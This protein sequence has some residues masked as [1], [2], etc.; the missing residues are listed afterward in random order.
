MGARKGRKPSVS[1]FSKESKSYWLEGS[2]SFVIA[3][4]LGLA[5]VI[6]GYALYEQFAKGLPLKKVI[7]EKPL[8]YGAASDVL[9]V[10]NAHENRG[11]LRSDVGKI[12]QELTELGWVKSAV[13]K[14][15]WYDSLEVNIQ[16]RIPVLRWG[17]SEY[18]DKEGVRFALPE[19]PAVQG[20][21]MVDGPE[22]YN[23]NVLKM[24]DILMPWF[25]QQN[26]EVKALVLDPRLV[27]RLTLKNGVEVI[28]GKDNINERCKK[29]V[30]INQQLINKYDKYIQ[31]VDLRYQNGFSVRWKT[32]VKPLE[33]SLT[34]TGT[35][36]NGN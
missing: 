33:H 25:A 5:I 23:E 12:A 1:R 24:Y 4:I 22:G 11:Y 36:Q 18:L 16:E 32:G 10:V 34:A 27:W 9:K 14:K 8:V 28:L 21:F 2:G 17:E 31:S 26:V 7:L 19:T 29:L 15:Q 13:V 35:T 3:V 6:L 20:L 30:V